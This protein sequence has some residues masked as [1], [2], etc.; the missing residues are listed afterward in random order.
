MPPA[1]MARE[2]ARKMESEDG[3]E[4]GRGR[5]REEK[6]GRMGGREEGGERQGKRSARER[7]E[8][9]KVYPEYRDY[10]AVPMAYQA[11]NIMGVSLVRRL[12]ACTPCLAD[13]RT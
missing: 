4:S 12:A 5:G 10:S 7:W 9:Q 6:G 1:E 2:S 3:R 11:K 13:L 8:G